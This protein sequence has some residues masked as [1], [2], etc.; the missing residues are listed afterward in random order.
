MRYSTARVR[1]QLVVAVAMLACCL[2][3]TTIRPPGAEAY[4]PG[5]CPTFLCGRHHRK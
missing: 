5:G 4:T 1:G 3:T 2:A